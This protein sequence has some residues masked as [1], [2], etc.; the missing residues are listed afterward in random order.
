M[1]LHPDSE[2][3]LEI[4]RQSGC[5][6]YE[7]MTVAEARAVYA[8]GRSATQGPPQ[9]VHAV[10]EI[11]LS[12]PGGPLPVRL[13]RARPRE[14]GP[15]PLLVYFHGGG[16]VLGGIESHDGLCRR[17][18]AASRCSI[19]SVDYRLAPEH[20]FPAATD[21]AT[22]ALLGLAAM[23]EAMGF[24]PARIGVGGDSAGGTL[25]A[26]AAIAA[27]DQGGPALAFQ[28]LL[29]PVC[30]MAMDTPSHEQ[31]ATDHLL[32]GATLRWFGQHY[33]AGAA[34]DNWRASPLC[35]ARFD[36]LPPAFV[37]TASHDP[38]CDEGEAYARCLVAAGV[39]VTTWRVQGMLHGF[40][41]MDKL[42]AAAA[43]A[44]DLAARYLGFGLR[45]AAAGPTDRRMEMPE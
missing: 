39:P 8:A 10:E 16:W 2:K 36:G 42:I 12:G 3:L 4:L 33:L 1:N 15:A 32:T 5:P 26:V 41:P 13:Y 37:L 34:P 22:A 31:F 19:A 35:A 40:M 21:D 45:D 24:D 14:A 11:T 43:P 27:R 18:A 28:M 29:Y 6:P 23:S 30:D 25:A 7:D 17:L 44:T 9:P 20:P 38:L